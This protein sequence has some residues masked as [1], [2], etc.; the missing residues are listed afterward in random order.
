[1]TNSFSSGMKNYGI[2]K[3]V[4]KGV[5]GTWKVKTNDGVLQQQLRSSKGRDKKQKHLGG[6]DMRRSHFMGPRRGA[7]YYCK[8]KGH[9]IRDCP[10]LRKKREKKEKAS[11]L[12]AVRSDVDRNDSNTSLLSASI[13]PL[14]HT[15]WVID[16]GA[17]CH[18]T[19]AR[20]CFVSYKKIDGGAVHMGNDTS[21]HVVGVG[22][23]RFRMH[24]GVVRTITDVRH[25]PMLRRSLLS[26]GALS[27]LGMRI[28]IDGENLRVAKGSLV[29][30]KGVRVNDIYVLHGETVLEESVVSTD[31]SISDTTQL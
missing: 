29:V 20:S 30:M 6:R 2:T 16:S 4:R 21:C 5:F 15:S 27:R 12:P 13:S 17:S 3:F 1:M 31:S 9:F 14:E 24:D 19:P 28:I 18:M 25:V 7:C 26:V 10:A 22:S 23:V 11:V 8:K